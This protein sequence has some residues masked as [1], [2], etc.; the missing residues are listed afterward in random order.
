MALLLYAPGVWGA[1]NSASFSIDSDFVGVG[2]ASGASASFSLEDTIAQPAPGQANSASFV[3]N[4]G[5]Q[6][7]DQ[8]TIS[9][10]LSSNSLNLGEL[11]VNQVKTV[12]TV[13][14]VTTGAQNG[15]TLS[16]GEVSGSSLRPVS[17]GVVVAGTE[18]YGIATTGADA[19]VMGDV[20]VVVG[21]NLATHN[22]AV[23]GSDTTLVFKAAISNNT[24]SGV[25]SQNIVLTASAN[26]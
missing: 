4:G 19:L 1:M 11:A 12:S 17:G 8:N 7:V 15:Y 2:G 26:P 16:I 14:S 9:V 3:I 22:A 24:S 6:Q 5:F 25:Y 10:A 20:P 23:A 18:A 13:A 21:T